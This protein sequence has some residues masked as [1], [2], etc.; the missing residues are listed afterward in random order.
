MYGR[1]SAKETGQA[2]SRLL[3]NILLCAPLQRLA[4]IMLLVPPLLLRLV[5]LQP[6]HGTAHSSPNPIA[7]PTRVIAQLALCLLCLA[8]LILSL[9]FLLQLLRSRQIAEILLARANRLVP[10]ARRAVRV[11]LGDGAFRRGGERP[12]LDGRVRQVLLRVGLFLASFC[13]SL[14][15][16][17][18]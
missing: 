2:L 5:P 4:D 18:D 7:N 15:C 11:V 9:S 6:R 17:F 10:R 8:L 13:F 16:V 12:R 3:L 1:K 14:C